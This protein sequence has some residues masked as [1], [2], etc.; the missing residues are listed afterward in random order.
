MLG[1]KTHI[2]AILTRLAVVTSSQ[3]SDQRNEKRTMEAWNGRMELTTNWLGSQSGCVYVNVIKSISQ[4]ALMS[5]VSSHHLL[6]RSDQRKLDPPSK[7]LWSVVIRIHITAS[8]DEWTELRIV[9]PAPMWPLYVM[10]HMCMCRKEK[11]WLKWQAVWRLGR[12]KYAW[13][14]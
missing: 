11:S 5:W 1:V 12:W 13:A 8:F 10:P 7:W 2:T 4:P 6:V 3:E 9:S 14:N